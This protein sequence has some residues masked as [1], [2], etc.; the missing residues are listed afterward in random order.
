MEKEKAIEIL[1]ALAW[2][3][4]GPDREEIITAIS[5]AIKA[6]QTESTNGRLIDADA[7]KEYFF[8]P[9]SNEESYSNIDIA[10]IIDNAPTVQAETVSEDT[11]TKTE[12]AHIKA[13]LEDVEKRLQGLILYGG[14]VR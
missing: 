9:Y 13:R 7:L 3:Q 8:R 12:L 10:K 14:V 6:L 2:V 1:N 11:Q 5:I 4:G